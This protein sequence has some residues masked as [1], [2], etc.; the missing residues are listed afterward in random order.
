[1]NKVI[2]VGAGVCRPIKIHM[3]LWCVDWGGATPPPRGM[4]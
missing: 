3:G 4:K 1:M 2:T